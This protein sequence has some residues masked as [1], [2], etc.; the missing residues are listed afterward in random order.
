MKLIFADCETVGVDPSRHGL[1]ELALIVREDDQ[2][3]REYCWQIRPDLT[4]AD[5]MALKIGRYYERITTGSRSD[6]YVVQHPKVAPLVPGEHPNHAPER[7]PSL[8]VAVLEIA[9]LLNAA[10]LAAANVAFDRDFIAAF[11]R[12]NGQA[13]S[14][15]YHLLEMESYAAGALGWKPPWKLDRL[16]QAAGVEVPEVDRHS[17]LGDARGIR[18]LF[19][20]VQA[21]RGRAV[22][23]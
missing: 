16:L 17:A 4:N 10:T 2:P 5:P 15:D 12:A 13:L 22:A 1:W 21:M 8:E 20:A 11:L 3:D 14:C 23:A 6:V 7:W 9:H 18:D 19:D